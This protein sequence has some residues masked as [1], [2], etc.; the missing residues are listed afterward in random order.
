LRPAAASRS[1][2]N[3]NFRPH[4]GP[5]AEAFAAGIWNEYQ[6]IDMIGNIARWGTNAL[7]IG[8]AMTTYAVFVLAK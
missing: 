4:K 5:A 8:M 6:E 7:L 3:V 1:T 2:G